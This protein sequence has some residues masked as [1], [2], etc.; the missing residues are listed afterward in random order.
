MTWIIDGVACS[1]VLAFVAVSLGVRLRLYWQPPLREE[2]QSC[3]FSLE[4]YE[5]MMRLL[6]Q[7]DL[8]YLKSQPGY[9]PETGARLL[10]QRRRIFR[11]Y[12]AS[13]AA[14]FRALH[15]EAR[16][17][18]AN[19]DAQHADFIR[20]LF[21]QELTFWFAIAA[22]DFRLMTGRLAFINADVRGLIQV[23]EAMRAQLSQA[24]AT[25]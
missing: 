23:L 16:Q 20:S 6:N 18:A 17:I 1:S 4:R 15:A 5:P 7:D 21:R 22:I 8:D 10:R 25:A 11:L 12:L 3:A 24:A 14:D 19:S 9:R 2:D 13:L